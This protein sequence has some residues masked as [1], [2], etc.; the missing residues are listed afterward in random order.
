VAGFAYSLYI[1]G[2]IEQNKISSVV[3]FVVRYCRRPML[4]ND[5]DDI[6]PKSSV[7]K[8][9]PPFALIEMFPLLVGREFA[10]GKIYNF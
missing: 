3:L 4:A 10:F 8:L 6:A 7:A 5:A 2:G 9:L 1:V